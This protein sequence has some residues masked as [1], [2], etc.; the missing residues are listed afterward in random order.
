MD[1]NLGG[2]KGAELVSSD[3]SPDGDIGEK[4]E[5]KGEVSGIEDC[6]RKGPED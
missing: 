3:I 6:I 1:S 4:I 5:G 2:E